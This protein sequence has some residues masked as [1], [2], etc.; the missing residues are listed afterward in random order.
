MHLLSIMILY[1]L[2]IQVYLQKYI[3]YDTFIN[4]KQCYCKILSDM[5]LERIRKELMNLKCRII[6]CIAK[7]RDEIKIIVVWNMFNAKILQMESV[8]F[9]F[10]KLKDSKIPMDGYN[11]NGNLDTCMHCYQNLLSIF[12]IPWPQ[13]ADSLKDY[14]SISYQV[15]V[16]FSSKVLSL[17]HSSRK[18]VNWILLYLFFI[19]WRYQWRLMLFHNFCICNS[20]EFLYQLQNL[21]ITKGMEN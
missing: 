18:N 21:A 5:I 17:Q 3:I 9:I 14:S 15:H 4:C 6:C 10:W 1:M 16:V 20:F 12:L 2:F 13:V 11:L 7:F 19:L 8:F